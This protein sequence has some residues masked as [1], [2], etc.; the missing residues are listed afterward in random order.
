MASGGSAPKP[1]DYIGAAREQGRQNIAAAQE[2]ARLNRVGTTGPYG[3]TSWSGSDDKGWTL[4]TVLDPNQQNLLTSS[5][6]N[7]NQGNVLAGQ[8]L[9]QYGSTAG[10]GIDRSGYNARTTSVPT[11]PLQKTATSSGIGQ[12]SLDLNGLATL[13]GADDFSADR[14]RVEDAY[15]NQSLRTL[16]PQW[17]QQE[18]AMRTRLLNSGVREGSEAW[19][20]SWDDFSRGRSGAYADARDRSIINAGGEQSRMLND[21]LGIRQQQFG[22]RTTAGQ[23]SNDAAAQQLN[24]ELARLGFF[25]DASGQEFEQAFANA[26]LGNDARTAQFGE[27]A[28]ARS[29]QLDELM[30]LIGMSQ[31]PQGT[32]N[33]A[34]AGGGQGVEPVDYM[35]AMQNS[36]AGQMNQYSNRVASA[37]STNQ[38]GMSALAAALMYFSDRRV[39]RDITRIG[40]LP[41]GLPVYSF[42]YLWDDKVRRGVMA[43]EVRAVMPFAVHTHDSGYDM[44]DY[45]AIGA[46]HLVEAA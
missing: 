26:N 23:F 34:N 6:A 13:P 21:S 9:Q 35:G 1:P 8:A 5:T 42:R 36:Y 30:S 32:P 18:E 40:S 37:N 19:Q 38:A 4:N 45:A 39:K 20:R 10:S 3:T 46:A 7:A 41:N 12:T 25:N 29:M 16:D 17:Q 43:D 2:N 44:V 33:M 22:E 24:A 11:T 31:G 28:T 15:Y 27:D 14:R